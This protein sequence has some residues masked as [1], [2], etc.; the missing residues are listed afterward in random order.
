VSPRRPASPPFLLTLHPDRPL[1]RQLYDGLRQA[2][3]EGRL[4]PAARLPS[5]RLLA[6]ELGISRN[7]VTL[8]FDQ[9]RAEG[10]IEGHMRAGTF[11]SRTLPD[12]LLQ[13]RAAA[14]PRSRRPAGPE[15]SRRGSALARSGFAG[16]APG[17]PRPFRPGIAGLDAFPATLWARL[18]GRRWR[19]AGVSL[20]YGDAAGYL[21][22]REAIADYVAR[23]RA[24]RCSADQVLVVSGSQQGLDLAA[25]VLLDPG[26]VA[27]IEEPGYLGARAALLAAGAIL[28]PV[29][30]DRHGL[31]VAAGEHRAPEARLAYVSPSH[32]FPLGVTLSATRRLE[33]LRWARRARAWVLE[34]D[35]DS[36]YRYASRPLAS[37]QGLDDDGR[38]VYI[39][40]FSKTLFP[41]L[42]LGYVIAPPG[43]EDAFRAAR[44]AAD[45]HSPSLEQAVLAD[46]IGA[47]HFVRHVRRMRALYLERRDA[48][49][50]AITRRLGGAVE[51]GP[52]EAG[53]HL[54]G[55]LP[56][57][58][59]DA[60][61]SAALAEAGVEAPPLSRYALRPLERAGLLL[62]YAGFSDRALRAAVD[63]AAP[64]LERLR[65]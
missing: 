22:L 59:D 21:P 58:V 53:M 10:Y 65:S 46:F 40:T 31:D 27:W 4:P 26:E 13:T 35:Y 15:L 52:A 37:L 55:W 56:A 60:A 6:A 39:G 36:E 41:G 25:R 51:L 42:R 47:G 32:Q 20:G 30:V 12:A 19:S 61:V 17:R 1:Q 33:L 38:V 48:L 11:V 8:V 62:G 64:V 5:A 43:T 29:P 63:R 49:R 28:A 45:R 44:A 18:T 7:T 2:I 23:A 57:G 3:G 14:A 16:G 50:D 9:L 34:D 24:A 54:L